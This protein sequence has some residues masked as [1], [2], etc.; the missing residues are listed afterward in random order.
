MFTPEIWH[1][2]FAAAGTLLGL[3]LRKKNTDIPE[4][5]AAAIARLHGAY[6]QSRA[7]DLL[8]ELIQSASG[9]AKT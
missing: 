6:Q 2:L 3:W 4:E 7:L 9:K 1:L 8:N 5:L